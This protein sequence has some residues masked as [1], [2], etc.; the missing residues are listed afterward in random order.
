MMMHNIT[1]AVIDN[2]LSNSSP[3]CLQP[4]S[5]SRSHDRPSTHDS[6]RSAARNTLDAGNR[7]EKRF[8]GRALVNWSVTYV[9]RRW[10]SKWKK[11]LEN[12]LSAVSPWSSWGK[13]IWRCATTGAAMAPPR[14]CRIVPENQYSCCPPIPRLFPRNS[15]TSTP[16]RYLPRNYRTIQGIQWIEE[17]SFSLYLHRFPPS[18]SRS[19]A[20]P[21]NTRW[22][23]TVPSL[24]LPLFLHSTVGK[25][26]LNGN[27][28]I[29]FPDPVNRARRVLSFLLS[30]RFTT[31]SPFASF[32]LS[33][34]LRFQPL[35][36]CDR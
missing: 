29:R 5:K 32:S 7:D 17:F 25:S 2:H 14:C 34:F 15:L 10:I 18:L 4:V 30:P 8:H 24:S 12:P 21:R 20:H 26:G 16:Q 35:V 23:Y 13:Q 9:K 31:V 28:K 3:R 22:V 36:V 1:Q 19:F 33:L 6:R 27:R 11:P